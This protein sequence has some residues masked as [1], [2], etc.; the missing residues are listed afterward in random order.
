M[1]KAQVVQFCAHIRGRGARGSVLQFLT[2]EANDQ[3]EV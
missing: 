1:T 2:D 3:K